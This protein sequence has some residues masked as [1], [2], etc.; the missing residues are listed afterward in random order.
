MKDEEQWYYDE[1]ERAEQEREEQQRLYEE[2][3]DAAWED[4]CEEED[5]YFDE[6]NR[7]IAEYELNELL[8]SD[9]EEDWGEDVVWQSFKDYEG[10]FYVPPVRN[11]KRSL[12]DKFADMDSYK[13]GFIIQACMA[14]F[15][16]IGIG[17]VLLPVILLILSCVFTLFMAFFN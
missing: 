10:E 8:E 17:I 14:I 16:L 2:E 1:L 9:D 4:F 15:A 11:T 3:Q 5:R 13:Q 12:F 7:Q 6:L